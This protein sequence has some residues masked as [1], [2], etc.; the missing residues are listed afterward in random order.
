M[1][2]PRAGPE[3]IVTGRQRKA[4]EARVQAA[5]TKRLR[6]CM[7]A[8]RRGRRRSFSHETTPRNTFVQRATHGS[9]TIL[10]ERARASEDM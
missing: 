8:I 1:R 3:R 2:I 4:P 5:R 6:C 9:G 7:A 10:P